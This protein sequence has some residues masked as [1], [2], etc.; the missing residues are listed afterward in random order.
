MAESMFT[1]GPVLHDHL[2]L[3]REMVVLPDVPIIRVIETLTNL[4]RVTR[5]FEWTARAP[6]LAETLRDQNNDRLEKSDRW[7]TVDDGPLVHGLAAWVPGAELQPSSMTDSDG[8]QLGWTY[9]V[10][11]APGDTVRLAVLHARSLDAEAAAQAIAAIAADPA[12]AFADL[13]VEDRASILNWRLAPDGDDDGVSDLRE[14][15]SG[16]HPGLADADADGVRDANELRW[17]LNPNLA[18]GD[19]DLDGDGLTAAEEARLGTSDLRADTDGDTIPDLAERDSASS[20][21]DFDT[22]GAGD[23]DGEEH[24]AGRDP[25]DPADDRVFDQA[26]A[27]RADGLG[28]IWALDSRGWAA[29]AIDLGA[30]YGR[31]LF[32]HAFDLRIGGYFLNE[33]D[34][35]ESELDDR[36]VR[37]SGEQRLGLRIER[38]VYVSADAGFARGIST[39]T[40]MTNQTVCAP[41]QMGL[42]FL[43]ALQEARATSS[44]G[45]LSEVDRWA[46]FDPLPRDDSTPYIAHIWA[47]PDGIAPSAVSMQGAI[48]EVEYVLCIEPGERVR[49][50]ALAAVRGD[51]ATAIQSAEDLA[52]L[53]AEALEGVGLDARAEI[54]NW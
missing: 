48:F 22:D 19:S 3:V 1:V 15:Q 10:R 13:A 32:T 51:V 27:M 26:P 29:P 33:G 20:P 47:G 53:P 23:S 16:S 39:L 46:V 28:Y 37:V 52:A 49:L 11:L 6:A 7:F 42:R 43:Q 44:G 45:A 40:N 24:A 8:R 12:P 34:T 2:Q 5:T 38:Q 31:I 36:Q 41:V 14:A 17:G 30:R 25:S 9:V 54:I 35:F 21:S 18:D 50:L 4:D